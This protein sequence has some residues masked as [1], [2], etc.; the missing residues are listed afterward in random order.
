MSDGTVIFSAQGEASSSPLF[1]ADHG[2]WG[3]LGNGFVITFLEVNYDASGQFAGIFKLRGIFT[4]NATGDQADVNFFVEF[5]DAQG[6][7]VFSG[8]GSGHSFRIKLEAPPQ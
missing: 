8:T 1:T 4:L 2:V 5:T 7:P 3:C 6:Q